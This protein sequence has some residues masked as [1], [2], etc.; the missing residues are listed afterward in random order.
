MITLNLL[1]L[2]IILEIPSAQPSSTNNIYRPNRKEMPQ[3][4]LTETTEL[5]LFIAGQE[6]T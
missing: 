3:N 2:H 1:L 4:L 5:R 6:M